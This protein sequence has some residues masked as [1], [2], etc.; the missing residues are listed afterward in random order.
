M[1]KQDISEIKGQIYPR[2]EAEAQF[3]ALQ[4]EFQSGDRLL[5]EKIKHLEQP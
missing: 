4:N 3:N 2:T 1:I 5:E